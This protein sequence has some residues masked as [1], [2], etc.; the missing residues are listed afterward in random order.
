MHVRQA[1]P[2]VEKSEHQCKKQD[3]AQAEEIKLGEPSLQ[4]DTLKFPFN[5]F[6]QDELP[7]KETEA[8]KT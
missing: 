1:P 5:C 7:K 2:S 8:M 4:K 3:A 6:D